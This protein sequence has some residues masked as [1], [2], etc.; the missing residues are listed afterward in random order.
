MICNF[1]GGQAEQ[2]RVEYQG[3]TGDIPVTIHLSTGPEIGWRPTDGGMVACAEC[4]ALYRPLAPKAPKP[5]AAVVQ[6]RGC[7]ESGHRLNFQGLC[8]E[9]AEEGIA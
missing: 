9:C 7:G 8:L 3:W 4:A 2:G 6:C 1:C 5:R